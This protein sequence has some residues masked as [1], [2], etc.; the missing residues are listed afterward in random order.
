M[1]FIF[2]KIVSGFVFLVLFLHLSQAKVLHVAV[3]GKKEA[4]GSIYSPMSLSRAFSSVNRSGDTILIHGGDYYGTHTVWASGEK[5]NP[6]VVMPYNNEVVRMIGNGE[7]NNTLAVMGDF[8]IIRDLIITQT[9]RKRVSA[10]NDSWPDDVN[11]ENGIAIGGEG[12]KLINCIIYNVYSNGLG[13]S[14]SGVDLEISGCIIFHAGWKGSSRGAGHGM[15]HSNNEGEKTIKKNIIFNTYGHGIQF[16]TEGSQKLVGSTFEDNIIFNAGVPASADGVGINRNFMMG[17]NASISDLVIRGNYTYFPENSTG[18]GMQIGYNTVNESCIIEDNYVARGEKV[19]VMYRFQS[20]EMQ[21][22]TI[23]GDNNAS[24]ATLYFPKDPELRGVYDWDRNLYIGEE[25]HFFYANNNVS[26]D[27]NGWQSQLGFD[28]NSTF[29]PFSDILNHIK[30]I[31]NDYQEGRA[32]VV[33][34]NWENTEKVRVDLGEVLK[35]DDSYTIYD[36]ENVFEPLLE[37]KYNGK[38][39]EI[40]LRLSKV[41]QPSGRGVYSIVH[42]GIEFGCFLLVSNGGEKRLL[43]KEAPDKLAI[44]KVYPNPTQDFVV[45]EYLLPENGTV[46]ASVYDLQGHVMVQK[47]ENGIAGN[48]KFL[49]NLAN[50]KQN[51]YLISLEDGF[52]SDSCNIVVNR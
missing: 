5:G 42:T 24:L 30:V 8:T 49:I 25:E 33:I 43:L 34:Y 37:G 13:S 4:S 26:L 23:I 32:H 36:V 12:V 9:E 6:L 18:T 35:K 16:Y 10:T 21:N 28:R 48:N 17:G 3:D 39:V 27:L 15:Y 1:V 41:I 44:S 29:K 14:S 52:S 7:G 45:I 2:K 11:T 22:N 50:L 46:K 31:P 19:F 38:S 40:P 20:T 51:T 47:E